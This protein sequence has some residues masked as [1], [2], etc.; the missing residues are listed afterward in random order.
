MT[1]NNLKVTELTLEELRYKYIRNNNAVDLEF[2]NQLEVTNFIEEAISQDRAIAELMKARFDVSYDK[3]QKANKLTGEVVKVHQTRNGFQTKITINYSQGNV[4]V[5]KEGNKIPNF[6]HTREYVIL[7]FKADEEVNDSEVVSGI[8][9]VAAG[10]YLL[11]NTVGNCVAAG[12]VED[13]IQSF[14]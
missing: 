2:I 12:D 9:P 4:S 8:Y 7:T 3:A 10:L 6:Y 11:Q 1:N 5:L 13:L 14:I